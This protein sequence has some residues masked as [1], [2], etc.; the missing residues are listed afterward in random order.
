MQ[1]L[2]FLNQ[3]A[4]RNHTDLILIG[5]ENLD[6]EY[7]SRKTKSIPMQGNLWAGSELIAYSTKLFA[8][9]LKPCTIVDKVKRDAGE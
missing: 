8:I 5:W 1:S 4:I 2:E 6:S 9:S 7:F 3:S